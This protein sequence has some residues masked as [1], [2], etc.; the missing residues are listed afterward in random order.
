[1]DVVSQDIP[2]ETK[3]RARLRDVRKERNKKSE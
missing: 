1:M 3:E 2:S